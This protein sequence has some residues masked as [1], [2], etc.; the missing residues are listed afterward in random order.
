MVCNRTAATFQHNSSLSNILGIQPSS[1]P[2][3]ILDD[4]TDPHGA[5][6][7]TTDSTTIATASAA[8]SSITT[9][10]A[11][12]VAVAVAST[13][14]ADADAAPAAVATHLHPS[15]SVFIHIHPYS[16]IFIHLHLPPSAP[17]VRTTST[18]LIHLGEP[19]VSLRSTVLVTSHSASGRARAALATAVS[20]IIDFHIATYSN[21]AITSAASVA[22]TAFIASHAAATASAALADSHAASIASAALTAARLI[23]SRTASGIWGAG[24][25][26]TTF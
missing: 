16:S 14:T 7:D 6:I 9:A 21:T 3:N 10:N 23:A 24:A 4:A 26:S 22:S 5:A 1:P 12:N 11:A 18:F 20:S 19:P 2:S 8:S 13:L 17:R 25:S 15:S